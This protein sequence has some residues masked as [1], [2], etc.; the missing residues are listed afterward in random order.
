MFQFLSCFLFHRQP[1]NVTLAV[2]NF[3]KKD[4]VVANGSVGKGKAVANDVSTSKAKP[5]SGKKDA[6][7]KAPAPAAAGAGAG[8]PPVITGT[9]QDLVG[10]RNNIIFFQSQAFDVALF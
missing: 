3:R 10:L 7:G 4:A 2:G 5:P 1:N 9:L 6:A 8:E